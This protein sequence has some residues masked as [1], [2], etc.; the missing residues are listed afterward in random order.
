MPF[1]K[2]KPFLVITFLV[3]YFFCT[4]SRLIISVLL[5]HP[6]TEQNFWR[7]MMTWQALKSFKPVSVRF[8][9][10]NFFTG[11]FTNHWKTTNEGA[12]VR[13]V[14]KVM[15]LQNWTKSLRNSPFLL[16]PFSFAVKVAKATSL[17]CSQPPTT[18]ILWYWEG[19]SFVRA[20]P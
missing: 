11:W 6:G 16:F 12:V 13:Q 1:E 5:I 17:T 18:L 10:H 19:H 20:W 3:F 8:L 14:C 9:D 7:G 4:C 15:C 2:H